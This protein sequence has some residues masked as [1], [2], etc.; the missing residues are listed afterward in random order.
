MNFEEYI[1]NKTKGKKVL[2]LGGLGNYERY[3]KEH[4]SGWRHNRLRKVAT[5]MYGGDINKEGIECVNQHGYNYHYLNVEC[6]DLSPEIGKFDVI[7]LL[8]VIEHLNN[9]GLSLSNIK[10]YMDENSEF[11]ISTPNPFSFNNFIRLLLGK[12]PNT[13]P[14]HTM[15]LDDVNIKQLAGRYGFTIS[16]LNYFTFEPHSSLKQRILNVSGKINKIFHQNIYV[17]LKLNQQ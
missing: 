4:F 10:N 13:L 2:E 5:F 17:I 9:V 7:L 1:E 14:D 6:D 15:W 12:K 3:K 11:I 16:E 8:D